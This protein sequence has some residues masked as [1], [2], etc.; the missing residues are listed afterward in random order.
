[1]RKTKDLRTF[2]KRVETR[3]IALSDKM[4]LNPK[5]KDNLIEIVKKL[6]KTLI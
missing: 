4:E 1:M 3:Y 5:T 6:I 2:S